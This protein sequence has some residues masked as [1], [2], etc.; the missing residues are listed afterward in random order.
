M[1]GGFG[2]GKRCPPGSLSESMVFTVSEFESSSVIPVL[3]RLA[4]LPAQGHKL[5]KPRIHRGLTRWVFSFTCW[6]SYSG[7][8]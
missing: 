4:F 6:G 2:P 8:C 3:F 7:T 1:V 5:G